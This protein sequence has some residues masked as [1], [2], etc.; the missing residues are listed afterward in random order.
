MMMM[1]MMIPAHVLK[2]KAEVIPVPVGTTGT[3][4]KSLKQH[5]SNIP[6][7]HEIEELQKQPHWA[8]HRL[9]GVLM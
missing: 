8:L 1:M 5:P 7:R 6:G 3:I 2:V 4:S 9:R